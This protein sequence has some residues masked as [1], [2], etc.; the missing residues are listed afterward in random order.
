MPKPARAKERTRQKGAVRASRARGVVSL[1]VVLAMLFAATGGGLY[2]LYQH[3]VVKNPGSHIERETIRTTIGSETQ[4][5]YADGVTPIGALFEGEHR[6]WVG[7]DELPKAWVDAIV[8]AEDAEFYE[9]HGF[10]LRGFARA[11][12]TNFVAMRLVAGGSTITQQTA[13]NLY[14]RQGRSVEEKLVEAL[15]ALRLE[16]HYTKNDILEFYANQFHVNANGRG[17]AVAARY[18]FNA[19]AHELSERDGTNA[20]DIDDLVACAFIAGSVK[21]PYLYNPFDGT[22]EQRERRVQRATDRTRYVLDQ[23]LRHGKIDA[24]THAKALTTPIPFRRGRFQFR[25]DIVLDAVREQLASEGFGLLLASHGIENPAVA[26]LRIVTTIDPLLQRR[27]YAGFRRALGEVGALIEAKNA[28]VY[29]EKSATPTQLHAGEAREFAVVVGTVERHASNGVCASPKGGAAGKA[30]AKKKQSGKA[31]CVRVGDLAGTIDA[32]AVKH[33]AS[34]VRRA[35]SLRDFVAAEAGDIE[36][37]YAALKPGVNVRVAV[38]AVGED[39]H[40]TLTPIAASDLQ[41]ATMILRDGKIRALIGGE[42]NADFNRAL[43]AKRQFGSTFKPA[44]YAAALTL[45]YGIADRLDNRRA[46]FG[47]QRDFYLPRP[48]HVKRPLDV[49]VAFAGVKSENLATVA[50]FYR[51]TDRLSDE[52]FDEL[53]ELMGMNRGAGESEEAYAKRMRDEVG[54][55]ATDAEITSGVFERV[56]RAYATDL[57]FEDPTGAEELARLFYGHGFD[58]RAAK[59][60]GDDAEAAAQRRILRHHFL[61]LEELATALPLAAGAVAE[62]FR[63]GAAIGP[64][65]ARRFFVREGFKPEVVITPS[66]GRGAVKGRGAGDGERDGARDGDGAG[67]VSFADRV[68]GALGLA[69]AGSGD[70]AGAQGDGAQGDGA[71]GAGEAGAGAEG[72][73]DEGERAD[74]S[75]SALLATAPELAFSTDDLE[76][77]RPLSADELASILRVYAPENPEALL[78]LARLNGTLR[79]ATVLALRERVEAQAGALMAGGNRYRKEVLY[80][81]TDFRVMVGMRYFQQFLRGA[82]VSSAVPAVLSAPLGAA[83]VTLAE[84][85]L[86]YQT[87]VTGRR[88]GFALPQQEGGVAEVAPYALIERVEDRVGRTL[89]AVEGESERVLA[90]EVTQPIARMLALTPL[91]G[92]ARRLLRAEYAVPMH[93]SDPARDR[94]LAQLSLKAM[95]GGKTGTTN[96]YRNAAFVGFVPAPPSKGAYADAAESFIVAAYAGYD[97]NRPMVRGSRKISGAAGGIPLWVEAAKA[98]ALAYPIGDRLDEADVGFLGP[99]AVL[100]LAV[101]ETMREVAVSAETGLVLDEGA[102]TTGQVVLGAGAGPTLWVPRG[103]HDRVLFAPLLPRG[104]VVQ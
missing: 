26:G 98:V 79:V 58:A 71:Q 16:A 76:G 30:V 43:S 31:I 2:A 59:V 92:T 35:V 49:S 95:V 104:F 50:L 19:T 36:G 63:A 89:Y 32:D 72:A 4:V 80:A 81:L 53:A 10:S 69:G 7:F 14:Y 13:K 24:E 85:A 55:L 68:F 97:D 12:W 28:G 83:D 34:I 40:L 88:H 46:A 93:A 33:A 39:E 67:D 21:G 56:K 96:S 48:D 18:F 84:M 11:M 27:A 38:S 60:R 29:V 62:K 23:M 20:D 100:P 8:A 22:K 73:G 90:D 77:W 42:S 87:L 6:S 57:A 54:L 66:A 47:F 61:R 74:D 103:E 70:G 102:T 25:R 78:G 15:N 51:L 1:V 41:G 101:P 52:Q 82:G 3:Y 45:G 94:V 91:Y 37:V 44:L 65:I 17:F 5:F 86:L 99:N 9:H 75:V 64:A